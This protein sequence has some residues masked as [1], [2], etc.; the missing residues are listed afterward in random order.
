[1][2]RKDFLQLLKVFINNKIIESSSATSISELEIK[3]NSTLNTLKSA[4]IEKEKELTNGEILKHKYRRNSISELKYECLAVKAEMML[5]NKDKKFDKSNTLRNKSI[6][7]SSNSTKYE[8]TSKLQ[9]KVFPVNEHPYLQNN[10]LLVMKKMS[11]DNKNITFNNNKQV[12][13]KK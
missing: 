13:N 12:I 6:E 8:L 7:K 5:N 2:K 11:R 4:K 9:N 3:A 1:V 10:S